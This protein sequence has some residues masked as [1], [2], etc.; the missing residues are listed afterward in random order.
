[1]SERFVEEKAVFE[2]EA[3]NTRNGGLPSAH[4]VGQTF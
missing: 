2:V 4:D 3:A 1:M